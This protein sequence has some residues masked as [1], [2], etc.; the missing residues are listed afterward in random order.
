MIFG[1]FKTDRDYP[2]GSE[3]ETEKETERQGE[4]EREKQTHRQI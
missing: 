1:G 4:T 3:G 2:R